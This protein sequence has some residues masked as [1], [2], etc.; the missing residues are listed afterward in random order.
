[1]STRFEYKQ[2]ITFNL[3]GSPTSYGEGIIL[4]LH[5]KYVHVELTKQ[6]KEFEVGMVIEVDYSEINK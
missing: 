3:D 1:M 4:R 6:C 2:K 5:S